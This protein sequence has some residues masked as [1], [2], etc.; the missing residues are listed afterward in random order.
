MHAAIVT[1]VSRGLGEALA[2][3]LLARGFAVLGVGRTASV[4][5]KGK[6]YHHATCDLAHPALIA[7]SVTPGLRA[8][9]AQKPESVTLVNNAAVVTPTGLVGHLDAAEVDGAFATNVGAPV[10]MADLFFRTFPDDAIERRIINISSGA[11]QSAIAGSA[12]YSMSKAALEMLTR[13]IAAEH[14]APRLRC[15]SLRP[16]IFET[17]MQAYMR[18]LDPAKVPSVGMFRGFK[19][20]GLLKDPAQVAAR[21]VDRLIEAPVENGRTYSHTDL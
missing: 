8:L 1:G 7:A 10:V 9:A 14:T 21:I 2:V 17:G 13:S 20:N 5:L 4:K 6:H 19:E 11:A 15:I 16:G 18:G 3:A 12:V